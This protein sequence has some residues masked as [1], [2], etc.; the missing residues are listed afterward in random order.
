MDSGNSW[1]AIKSRDEINS[2]DASN[3][4]TP[5]TI[6][7][8]TSNIRKPISPSSLATAG[9]TALAETPATATEVTN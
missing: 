1:D 2:R 3:S 5:T 6:I 8:D 9:M 7:M 4:E